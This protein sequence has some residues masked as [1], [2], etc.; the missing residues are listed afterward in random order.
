MTDNL[1]LLAAI[2]YVVS[3]VES[4]IRSFQKQYETFNAS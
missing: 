3:P 4:A 1:I 2:F